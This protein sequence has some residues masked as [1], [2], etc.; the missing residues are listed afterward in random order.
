MANMFSSI[1]SGNSNSSGLFNINF[2]DYAAIRNGSYRKLLAAHFDL[3]SGTSKTRT[4]TAKD[5]VVNK[6]DRYA[7]DES[8]KAKD[9]VTEV[10]PEKKGYAAVQSNATELKSSTEKLMETGDKSVYKKV[11]V[12]DEA[13]ETNLQYDTDAIYKA[14]KNFAD[15]YNKAVTAGAESNSMNVNRSARTMVNYTK[16]NQNALNAIGITIGSDNKLTVDEEKFKSADMERVQNLFTGSNSYGSQISTQATYMN[17]YA[18]SAAAATSTYTQ[19]G[20]YNY[21]DYSSMFSSSI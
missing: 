1:F 16:A 7:I 18:K 12:K 17:N 10:N 11:E 8:S 13:G 15:D 6:A 21:F 9:T 19:S 2:S 14:V 4:V 20:Q 5:W 3:Q